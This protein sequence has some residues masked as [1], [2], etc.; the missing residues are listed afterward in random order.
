MQ[1]E[2][3]ALDLRAHVQFI[4]AALKQVINADSEQSKDDWHRKEYS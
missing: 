3:L 4:T 2:A 1:H